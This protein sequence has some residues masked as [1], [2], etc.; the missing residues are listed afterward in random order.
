[1]PLL[2]V[3]LPF[4]QILQ[5]C[6]SKELFQLLHFDVIREDVGVVKV[7]ITFYS[8]IIPHLRQSVPHL[9]QVCS[10][11]EAVNSLSVAEYLYSQ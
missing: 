7:V 11:F 4:L 8:D 10:T 9:R 3:G 5:L 2:L 6:C 1:M